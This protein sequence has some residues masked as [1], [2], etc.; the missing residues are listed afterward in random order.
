MPEPI[1]VYCRSGN[2]S[3]IAVSILAQNGIA[4]AVNGGG[5]DDLKQSMRE[6]KQY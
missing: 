1:I 5:L 2:R 4:N 3:G 6:G